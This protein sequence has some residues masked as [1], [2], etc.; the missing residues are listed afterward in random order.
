M[1]KFRVDNIRQHMFLSVD[2]LEII[3]NNTFEY[4]LYRLLE[5]DGILSEFIKQYKNNIAGNR[6]QW[7]FSVMTDQI[8]EQFLTSTGYTIIK[9]DTT[10]IPRDCVWICQAPELS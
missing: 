8:M 6:S 2:F 10:M 5:R 1:G 9:K 4:S 3:G 7:V